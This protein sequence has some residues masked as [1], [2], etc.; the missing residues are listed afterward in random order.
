M[1]NMYNPY[2][3]KVR[4][5]VLLSGMA[6]QWHQVTSSTSDTDT[7]SLPSNHWCQKCSYGG[8]MVIPNGSCISTLG[9]YTTFQLYSSVNCR[10]KGQRYLLIRKSV[11]IKCW[12]IIVPGHGNE[13]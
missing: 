12:S 9:N 6:C 13:R 2:S 7:V 3:D 1:Y 8:H 10:F 5:S 4:E 11:R